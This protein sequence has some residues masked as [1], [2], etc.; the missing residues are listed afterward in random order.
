MIDDRKCWR[1]KSRMHIV[2]LPGILFFSLI[3]GIASSSATEFQTGDSIKVRG[4]TVWSPAQVTRD[5]SWVP[6]C[7]THRESKKNT[8]TDFLNGNHES[9]LDYELEMGTSQS[10]KVLCIAHLSHD[11]LKRFELLIK[12]GYRVELTLDNLPL[13]QATESDDDR[14]RLQGYAVGEILDDEL[15]IHNHIEFKVKTQRNGDANL[16]SSTWS[17]VGFQADVKSVKVT[18]PELT[19]CM[20]SIPMLLDPSSAELELVM[21]YSVVFEEDDVTWESRWDAYTN[22]DN[23]IRSG[24]RLLFLASLIIAGILGVYSLFVFRRAA[25]ESTS[26]SP[27]TGNDFVLEEETAV[28]FEAIRGDVFRTPSSPQY[29]TALVASGFQIASIA[30]FALLLAVLRVHSPMRDKVI[31]KTWM[32]V[33]I[34]SNVLAGWVCGWVYSL[35][36]GSNRARAV[37]LTTGLV[38]GIV[39]ILF[40][41]LN[42]LLWAANAAGAVDFVVLLGLLI[43]WFGLSLPLTIAG[44]FFA[45]RL[46]GSDPVGERTNLVPSVIQQP[47]KGVAF[48]C[49]LS[50]LPFLVAIEPLI[51]VLY[52]AVN[53]IPAFL[54]SISIFGVLAVVVVSF[55][56]GIISADYLLQNGDYRWWWLSYLSSGLTGLYCFVF[57]VIYIFFELAIRKTN[58]VTALSWSIHAAIACVNIGV[59]AGS[60]SFASGYVLVRYVSA[61]NEGA[62][63]TA[64]TYS[65]VLV[66]FTRMPWFS[67]RAEISLVPCLLG[68]IRECFNVPEAIIRSSPIADYL[69]NV[70]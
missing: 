65:G 24:K 43:T 17:I 8:L 25:N 29:M 57:S 46:V 52:A 12:R 63:P 13:L 41:L 36:G 54:F 68:C 49:R 33:A 59:A 3:H 58:L 22:T 23:V 27:Y 26:L 53:E 34:L 56:V 28:G 14:R 62:D 32:I 9:L 60:I 21:T 10:C 20:E 67:S 64:R 40:F 42:W 4:E 66:K 39:F 48:S 11:D 6:Y 18:Q 7:G 15:I 1:S 5:Y 51:L 69:D 2:L 55:E 70:L 35:T 50:L 16:P 44:A 61:P 31:M 38:P 30:D 45:F 47:R 37:L 19:N